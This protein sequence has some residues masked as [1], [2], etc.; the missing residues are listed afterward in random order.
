MPQF[1]SLEERLRLTKSQLKLESVLFPLLTSVYLLDL[2]DLT[3]HK[4]T[5]SMPWTSQLRLLKVRSK[6]PK[7]SRSAL[8]TKKWKLQKQ[9]SSKSLTSNPLNMVWKSKQ[10]MTKVASFPKP[11]SILTPLV[12]LLNS[13]QEPRTLLVFPFPLVFPLQPLFLLLL[14]TPSKTSLL[15]QLNQGISIN[16]LDIKLR[17]LKL[18]QALL[19]LLPKKLKPRN[20]SLR[21]K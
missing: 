13:K 10:S 17:K 14:E 11:S 21:N 15:C 5:S 20:K 1:M 3:P 19:P 9:L 7:I 6:S 4:L 18:L 12:S 16:I 8:K 2:P